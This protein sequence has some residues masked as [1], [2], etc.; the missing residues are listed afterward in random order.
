[1]R[2]GKPVA[3][4]VPPDTK[5]ALRNGAG[6]ILLV[7]G[8]VPV[9]RLAPGTA[10]S[11]RPLL[12]LAG[13][14]KA[15]DPSSGKWQR[16]EDFPSAPEAILPRRIAEHERDGVTRRTVF[17]FD[18]KARCLCLDELVL[19]PGA[20]LELTAPE[21]AP[22]RYPAEVGVYFDAPGG[23]RLGDASHHGIGTTLDLSPGCRVT[24]G[25]A[26]VALLVA[27][28]GAKLAD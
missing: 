3:L 25:D 5:W 18:Y 14:G 15:F 4:F 6:S 22:P 11:D 27:H 26:S 7:E 21:G 9:R 28:A 24:A 19:A 12:P 8:R 20:S 16:E 2:E 17:P 13:S 10:S 1:P 23:V